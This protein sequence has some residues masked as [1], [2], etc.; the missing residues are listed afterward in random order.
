[1]LGMLMV[2]AAFGG[3]TR[4]WSGVTCNC[5]TPKGNEMHELYLTF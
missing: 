2:A 4:D 5:G 1:M 3:A